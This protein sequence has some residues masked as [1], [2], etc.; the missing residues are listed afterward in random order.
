M[1]MQKGNSVAMSAGRVEVI[2]AI[3]P[4][5]EGYK[6]ILWNDLLYQYI[7]NVRLWFVYMIPF[8]LSLSLKM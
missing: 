4:D 7:G 6:S 2:E 5:L 3:M 8:N 1:P